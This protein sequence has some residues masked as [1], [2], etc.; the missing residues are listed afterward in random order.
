MYNPSVFKSHFDDLRRKKAYEEKRNLPLR[1]VAEES[2]LALSTVQRIKAGNM[3]KV[4]LS[5][6]DTLCR[7]FQVKN[8]SELI[9]YVPDE[10]PPG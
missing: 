9:E 2:G 6:L 1:A 5:T 8:L 3:E 7:Y 10:K 4:Y